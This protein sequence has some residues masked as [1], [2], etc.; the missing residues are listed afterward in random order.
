MEGTGSVRFGIACRGL[1]RREAGSIPADIAGRGH[2][3]GLTLGEKWH[4]W[5]ARQTRRWNPAEGHLT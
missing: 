4:G 2:N 5:P 3:P 1:V